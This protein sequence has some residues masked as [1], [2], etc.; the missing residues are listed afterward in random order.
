MDDEDRQEF[1]NSIQNHGHI[2]FTHPFD[3]QRDREGRG[4]GGL[5]HAATKTTTT[6]ITIGT[7]GTICM[8]YCQYGTKTYPDRTNTL[9]GSTHNDG[10]TESGLVLSKEGTFLIRGQY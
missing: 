3:G 10:I 9:S 5:D 8:D 1:S 2:I 4:E 7:D 6:T